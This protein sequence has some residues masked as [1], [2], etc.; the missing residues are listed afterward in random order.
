[1][2]PDETPTSGATSDARNSQGDAGAAPA[3]GTVR[4]HTLTPLEG[5][6]T[7]GE[8]ANIELLLDVSVPVVARLGSTEMRIREI[9]KLVPGSIVELNK[10]A[11]EPVDLYVRGKLFAEGEV[12]V[13]DE[14]FGVRLTRILSPKER[15]ENLVAS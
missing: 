6:A 1:M 5:D 13:V 15:A 7:G 2:A 8:E 3:D 4:A 12:V 10:L 11:G 9:L 14:N